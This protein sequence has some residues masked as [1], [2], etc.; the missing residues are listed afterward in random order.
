MVVAVALD[1]QTV[2][3]ALR[4][5]VITETDIE[6]AL[7]HLSMVRMRIGH[8]DPDGPLQKSSFTGA[9]KEIYDRTFFLRVVAA[10][11][12]SPGVGDLLR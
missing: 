4:M 2:S 12:F 8:F 1:A 5:G 7:R 6:T 10:C 3:S 11:D 9:I